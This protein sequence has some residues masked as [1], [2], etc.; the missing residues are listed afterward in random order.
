[1]GGADANIVDLTV[2]NMLGIGTVVSATGEGT[3]VSVQNANI[4]NN[5]ITG[6]DGAWVGIEAK[7][8]AIVQVTGSTLTSNT[9]S[10][11]LFSAISASTL[12]IQGTNVVGSTGAD[13][14]VSQEGATQYLFL[15][16]E[17]TSQ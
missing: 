13:I 6:A 16:M 3:E 12:T 11:A 2:Q 14:L 1:L 4:S 8:R 15:S 9:G 5:A 7:D 10:R 17:L